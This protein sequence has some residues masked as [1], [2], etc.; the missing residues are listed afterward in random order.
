MQ[1]LILA[2]TSRY[3]RELL[4]RLGLPFTTI[5]PDFDETPVPGESA[6][7][8]AKRLATG[9]AE[10][11]A[12]TMGASAAA[13]ITAAT[14]ADTAKSLQQ[15]II[16][17]SDQVAACGE[18]LLGK[19][20]DVNTAI[21][22]L[23]SMA[24]QAVTFHTAVHLLRP[25]PGGP[26]Q[27]AT[28]LTATNVTATSFTDVDKT[29]AVLRNLS[30]DEIERYVDQEPS[31]DCAGSFKVEGL[32]ISLFSAVNTNDP[33]GLIGLPLIATCQGLRELGIKLP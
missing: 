20:G 6:E 26:D 25:I 27:H 33:T 2:S 15:P 22:Q 12:A 29:T 14:V 13:A 10:A 28:N 24:G 4:A 7:N 19:P 5:S 17:G 31:L 16:I 23:L 32:G 9:K 11:V 30:R 21:E 1:A 18:Q 8:L 3:R